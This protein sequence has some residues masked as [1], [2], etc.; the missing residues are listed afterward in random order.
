MKMTYRVVLFIPKLSQIDCTLLEVLNCISTQ[1]F[2]IKV[3][4]KV[5]SNNIYSNSIT[6]TLYSGKFSIIMVL[7]FC[8]LYYYSPS[9]NSQFC[10]W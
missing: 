10:G 9:T 3:K 4:A 6:V 2:F 1:C 8:L 7:A 5:Y